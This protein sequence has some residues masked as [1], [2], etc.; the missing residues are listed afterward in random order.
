[1]F[2]IPIILG[3]TRRGRQS[4]KVARFV[5]ERMQKHERIETEILDLLDYDFPMLEERLRLRDDAP[6]GVVEFGGRIAR[7]DS[8]VIVSPEYNNGY[9]GVLKNAL[10]YF[11]PEY[12]R[13]PVA[14]VTV[15]GGGFGGLNALAQLR[16]VT[17]GMGAFPIPASL[18][19]SR[20]QDVFAEEGT[21]KDAA[22][23]KRTDAFIAEV[24]WFTEAIVTQKT[25]ATAE[26]HLPVQAQ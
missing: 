12:K 4:A 3:S 19:F 10:D 26:S 23:E 17:L 2:Y 6:A 7:A 15:S 14:I 24:L 5:A 22:Y 13:K 20:V 18:P 8:V 25:K 1:M 11:G 16:L 9:P 21:L